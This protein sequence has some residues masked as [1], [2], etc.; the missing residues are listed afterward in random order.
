MVLYRYF[1]ALLLKKKLYWAL[2]RIYE[3]T[4]KFFENNSFSYL[5]EG[6]EAENE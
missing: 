6:S 5:I 1:S 4:L 3:S 2:A